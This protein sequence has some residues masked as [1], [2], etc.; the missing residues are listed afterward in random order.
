VNPRGIVSAEDH[1]RIR[2]ARLARDASQREFQ[3][4]V[5]DV[6]TR[7]SVRETAKSAGVSPDT[8]VRWKRDN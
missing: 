8:I 6:T 3:S 2:A 7:S 4:I 1:E 5:V